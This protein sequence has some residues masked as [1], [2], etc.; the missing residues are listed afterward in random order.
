MF[1]D[2]KRL[3]DV[4]A[5]GLSVAVFKSQGLKVKSLEPECLIKPLLTLD[6]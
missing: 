3:E 2:G 1:S 4:I 6:S 5:L